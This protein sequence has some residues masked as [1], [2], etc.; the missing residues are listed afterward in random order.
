MVELVFNAYIIGYRPINCID[1]GEF[2]NN[3]FFYISTKNNSH[4][5]QSIEAN[6]KKY[7]ASKR[8]FLLRSKSVCELGIIFFRTI[9]ILVWVGNIDFYGM[10][11]MLDIT[12]W[13]LR[14]FECVSILLNFLNLIKINMRYI[15]F[16]IVWSSLET[17]CVALIVHLL[18]IT[19]LFCILQ[20]FFL[21]LFFCCCW[22]TCW[23]KL[24]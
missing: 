8:C 5:L 22:S 19:K 7:L 10:H 2:R 9:L 14:I 12:V 1:I 21:F 20:F 17:I 3:S 23:F 15:G 6:C 24:F 13:I 4:T 18:E 11:K 16:I